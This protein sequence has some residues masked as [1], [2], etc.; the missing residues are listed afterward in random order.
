M[1]LMKRSM[2]NRQA[3]KHGGSLFKFSQDELDAYNHGWSEFMVD[4]LQEQIDRLKISDSGSLYSS[5]KELV[6]TG[7]VTTIEHRFLM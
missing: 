6:Q 2:E 3:T 5:I 7:T 1:G 4:I